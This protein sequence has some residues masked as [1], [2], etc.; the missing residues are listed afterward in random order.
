MAQSAPSNERMKAA[1]NLFDPDGEGKITQEGLKNVLKTLGKTATDEELR[2]L[3]GGDVEG[4]FTAREGKI[5]YETFCKIFTGNLKKNTDQVTD[6]QEAFRLIDPEGKGHITV[7]ELQK[8]C[9]KM[10]E[11]L[12][13]EEVRASPLVS[14]VVASSHLEARCLGAV[15]TTAVSASA[16]ALQHA[17]SAQTPRCM[18]RWPTWWERRSSPSMGRSTTTAC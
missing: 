16:L 4:L 2:T 6:L 14:R 18:R 3:I 15:P 11:D 7:K 8:I 13:Q 5:D 12:T 9:K 1:F 10:G 17:L